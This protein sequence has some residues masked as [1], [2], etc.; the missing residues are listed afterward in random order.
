MGAFVRIYAIAAIALI[1]FGA[2]FRAR[3]EPQR[4]S[5]YAGLAITMS[6]AV[7]VGLWIATGGE[8]E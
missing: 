1:V 7:L 2:V 5:F 6:A 3:R 8:F 4:R